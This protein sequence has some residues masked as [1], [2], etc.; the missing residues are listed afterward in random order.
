VAKGKYSLQTLSIIDK[1]KCKK[2]R[3]CVSVNEN[4]LTSLAD[5]ELV[6]NLP[7]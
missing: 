1:R 4:A 5:L 3:K 6:E 7:L 2:I